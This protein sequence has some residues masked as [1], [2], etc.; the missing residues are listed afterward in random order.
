MNSGPFWTGTVRQPW[1][2]EE[3]LVV[4][5]LMYWTTT[6]L[7]V[8]SRNLLTLVYRSENHISHRRW[9]SDLCEFIPDLLEYNAL[10]DLLRNE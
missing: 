10:E 5:Y 9:W 6:Y 7:N 8:R 3:V 4:S 1:I 2:D